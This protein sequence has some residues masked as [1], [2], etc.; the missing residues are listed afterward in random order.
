ML[1]KGLFATFSANVH[2]LVARLAQEWP[3]SVEIKTIVLGLTDRGQRANLHVQPR[4][5]IKWAV[6][7]ASLHPPL[8]LE[9]HHSFSRN[10]FYRFRL[11]VYLKHLDKHGKPKWFPRIFPLLFGTIWKSSDTTCG[12]HLVSAGLTI[13]V[14]LWNEA[15]DGCISRYITC[16]IIGK[17]QINE[18]NTNHARE[19][20]RNSLQSLIG[21]N[22]SLVTELNQLTYV[23]TNTSDNNIC[24]KCL[25]TKQ[26]Y[27]MNHISLA[28]MFSK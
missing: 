4:A 26:R 23:N 15:S 16:L 5:V 18:Q 10:G 21:F 2:S 1:P 12:Y 6:I 17:E 28:E 3:I 11:L 24:L 14:A 8:S 20:G 9:K 25:Y 7:C 22:L 19:D 13:D 27:Y